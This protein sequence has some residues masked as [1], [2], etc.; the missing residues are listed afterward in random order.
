MTD[1][2]VK[3][4]P[5]R[6]TVSAASTM[7]KEKFNLSFAKRFRPGRARG[8]HRQRT[9]Q[10]YPSMCL[11]FVCRAIHKKFWR[12]PNALSLSYSNAWSISTNI[13][14][15]NS[16]SPIANL[17]HAISW[18]MRDCQVSPTTAKKIHSGPTISPMVL[19]EKPGH[20]RRRQWVD[21]GDAP[22]LSKTSVSSSAIITYFNTVNN[23]YFQRLDY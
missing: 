7:G 8:H 1:I 22:D 11:R 3:L 20:S 9:T 5:C 12:V 21:P 4:A 17:G 16:A 18:P 10:A 23:N 19:R 2:Q 14:L 15:A 13:T 6:L